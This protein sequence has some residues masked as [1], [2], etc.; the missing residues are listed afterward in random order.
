[1]F[2]SNNVV[3]MIELKFIIMVFGYY[4]II[5][6]FISGTWKINLSK[7]NEEKLSPTSGEHNAVEI[8]NDR[9]KAICSD[10]CDQNDLLT[11]SIFSTLLK[12]FILSKQVFP[13]E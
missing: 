1:M 10:M 11:Y 3:K 12:L 7:L 8:E 6:D 2:D 9:L 4:C 13:E 5:V